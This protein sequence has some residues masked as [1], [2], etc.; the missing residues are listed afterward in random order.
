[1]QG[2]GLDTA[3]IPAEWTNKGSEYTKTGH[4]A[5]IG[6]RVPRSNLDRILEKHLFGHSI[7]A[8]HSQ[9]R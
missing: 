9:K 2:A 3:T 1:M 7:I 6:M 4:S 8:L 5:G